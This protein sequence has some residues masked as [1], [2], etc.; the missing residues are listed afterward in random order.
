M[1]KLIGFL[2]TFLIL[3]CISATV[4]ADS[5]LTSTPFSK[6]Y[7]DI[8]LVQEARDQGAMNSDFATYLADENNPI[9]VKAAIINALSWDIDG[10]ENADTY[11]QLIYNTSL[12]ELD[13]NALPADQQFCIGYLLALD[14]YSDTA[15][16]MEYLR[17][18]RSSMS[19]S[20]TVAVVTYLVEAMNFQF[21]DWPGKYES[22]LA[23]AT[24]NKDMSEAA[25]QVI[26]D[27]I[28]LGIDNPVE[29][30]ADIPKTGERI[31]W[32]IFAVGAVIAAAGIIITSL[33]KRKEEK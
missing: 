13:V 4:S 29:K 31:L 20:L 6:A 3:F 11:C 32:G 23:D 1:K 15:Q 30:P 21:D 25:I 14:N 22:V 19:D 27:Y 7:Y 26:T 9:D 18:A 33:K 24:L 17:S 16:A 10:K 2:C 12:Q 5:P 8:E 28:V